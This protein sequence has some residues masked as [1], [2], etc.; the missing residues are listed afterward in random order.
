MTVRNCVKKEM[1]VRKRQNKKAG[2]VD[3]NSTWAMGRLAFA[4]QVH[5]QLTTRTS[6]RRSTRSESLQGDLGVGVQSICLEQIA[7][8]EE[9]HKKQV[10]GVES[11]YDWQVIILDPVTGKV[12]WFDNTRVKFPK[13][14]RFAFVES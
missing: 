8:W 5:T 1:H 10:I 2:N 14:A 11:K 3:V 4:R 9:K 13:E 12:T 7:F 6:G